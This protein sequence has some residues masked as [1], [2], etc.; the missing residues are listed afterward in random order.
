LKKAAKYVLTE[1]PPFPGSRRMG[2]ACT[3]RQLRGLGLADAPISFYDHHYCHATAAAFCSGFDDCLVLTLDGLGDALSGSISTFSDG[4]LTRLS[5]IPAADS[6]GILFEHVTNLLHMR[7]LEDE[8]KVMALSNYCCPVPD[9]ENPLLRLVR[10]DGLAVRSLYSGLRLYRKLK[11]ILWTFPPEQFAYMAQRL[12]ERSVVDLV[13]S[14]VAATGLSR[15]A[16]SG[17]VA[18]NVKVNRLIRLLPE[19]S[20]C[21]VFPHMGDGGLALGAAM[22]ANAE[23][24]GVTS[25]HF[26]TLQLGPCNGQIDIP[27]MATALG[28]ICRRP[29]NAAAEVADLLLADRVVLWVEGRMEIGPRALGGRS[30]LVRADSPTARDRLNLQLKRRVWY[31]PFCPSILEEDAPAVF[32]DWTTGSNA[33]MTMAQMVRPE[34][35]DT[36]RAVIHIDGSCRPHLVGLRPAA[37]RELLC[38]LKRRTGLGAVLNTS[39]NRHG[40]PLVNSPEEALR[41]LRDLQADAL[42]LD[43]WIIERGGT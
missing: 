27:A 2:T 36:L 17:G 18:S 12:L 6:L 21:Y 9:E 22:A 29:A 15:V 39:L 4:S 26:D 1:L 25:Y 31:Q 10:V 19:V 38:E 37:Y 14:A 32:E 30:I 34:Y 20:D 41:A 43:G 11:Q 8:G 16:F 13:R 33:F 40:E 3:R 28:L 23:L 42:F 35:R 5:A 24:F 7:E